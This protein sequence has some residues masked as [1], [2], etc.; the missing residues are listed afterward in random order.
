MDHLLAADSSAVEHMSK[1]S[2][3]KGGAGWM[4]VDSATLAED[5][6]ALK[7]QFAARV[8]TDLDDLIA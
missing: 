6:V 8:G 2:Q 7:S 5:V 1:S 4:N 3:R